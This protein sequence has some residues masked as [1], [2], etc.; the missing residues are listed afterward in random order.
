MSLLDNRSLIKQVDG[1]NYLNHLLDVP[2]QLI[3]GYEL[4]VGAPLV[5]LFAQ[6]R[7]VLIVAAGEMAPAAYAVATLAA[8]YGRVPVVVS[9]DYALPAWVSSDTL[10][11]AVDY[12]GSTGP[13]VTSFQEAAKR[14][15]RLLAIS[16]GGDL[17]KEARRVKASHIMV[18]Y[19]APARAAFA[20]VLSCLCQLFRRLDFLELREATV[21]EASSLSRS[22]LENI[23]PDVAH[24]QNPAKQLARNIS[25]RRHVV[26]IA[27]AALWAVARKWQVSLASTGKTIAVCSILSDFNDTIINGLAPQSKPT[28]SPL[29]IMLQSKYDHQRTKVQQTLTYQVSQARK[30][31]YEQV[32]MHPSGSNFGEIVLAGLMGEMVGYYLALLSHQD[33]SVTEASDYIREQS[34]LEERRE[35][36][37]TPPV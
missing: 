30:V 3:G 13:V 32:F 23:G 18:N 9:E 15:A 25:E 34:A 19:G 36:I 1:H 35:N 14:R 20:Y 4:A 5:A 26:V 22:L 21:T 24:Y 17:A 7:Q 28:E 11:V 10:V 8:N 16:L 37:P 2:E 29:V 27:G 33:P 12:Y 6:S 31:A